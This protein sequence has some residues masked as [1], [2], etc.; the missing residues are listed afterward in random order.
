MKLLNTP[1][2][3]VEDFAPITPGL[4]KIYTCGPTVYSY[5]HIGNLRTYVF[6]DVLKRAL[7]LHG[8]RIFQVMNITDVGH[9]TDDAD[10][11]EDKI[12]RA[13]SAL[14]QDPLLMTE[15]FKDRFFLD[16]GKLNILPPDVICRATDHIPEQI[17][18]VETLE[19]KGYTY[20]TDDGLYFDTASFQ[21]FTPLDNMAPP[22]TEEYSRV[23]AGQKRNPS[24]FALWKLSPADRQRQLEWD[25]PWGRG[26]PG[27]HIECSA[28]SMKYLGDRFDIHT[29]GIDHIPV[30]HTSEI[31]QMEA[32]V[33]HRV[34]G[35]WCHGGW[36]FFDFDESDPSAQKMSKSAGKTVLLSDLEARGIPPLA[37]RMLILTASY[38]HPLRASWTSLDQT[39]RSYEKLR[40]RAAELPPA[41]EAVPHPQYAERLLQAAAND[42]DTPAAMALTW[43]LLKDKKVPNPQKSATLGLFDR[44]LGLDLLVAAANRAATVEISSEILKLVQDRA[45]A[46]AAGDWTTADQLRAQITEL[47]YE[48]KDSPTGYALTRS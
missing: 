4:A 34:V 2:K 18:L 24:D 44:W 33:G 8:Y 21:T 3:Q 27:W 14:R 23:G 48:I 13:A 30:H 47:G 42:L 16:C 29:G 5:Q 38:R 6:A 26:F 7:H 46:R 28:M 1:Q 22:A 41:G 20:R 15:Q 10:Q 36:L 19:A 9:L 25:S 40:T 17:S 12:E 45:A 39:R 31:R 32:A 37:F 35:S 11:G 43:E